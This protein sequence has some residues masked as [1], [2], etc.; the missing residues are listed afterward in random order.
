MWASVFPITTDAVVVPVGEESHRKA[1][2]ALRLSPVGEESSLLFA[3]SP[4]NSRKLF[5]VVGC[6]RKVEGHEDMVGVEISP[7][8]LP[9][10]ARN[11]NDERPLR[12]LRTNLLSTPMQLNSI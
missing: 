3:V 7:S 9:L 11:E 8:R 1:F 10:R 2:A 5:D 4:D 6:R 12:H